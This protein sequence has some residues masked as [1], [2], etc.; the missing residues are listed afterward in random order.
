MTDAKQWARETVKG[1]W[2]SPLTP[3]LE[4]GSID[5]EGI[6]RNVDFLI[7]A[8][9]DGIGFGFS[10]PWVMSIK[11]R[12]EAIETFVGAARGRVHAYVHITD[13]S[14]VETIEFGR[15]AARLGADAV[16]AWT[17]FEWAKSQ[18]MIADFYQH[19]C[20][21]IPLP[22]FAYNTPHSGR[23]MTGQ[24]LD[25]IAD[26]P[27]LCA[28]KNAVNSLGASSALKRIA[29]D[30]LIVADPLEHNYP[31]AITELDQQVLLGTTSVYLMQS[32][33]WRP[34]EEYAA[35]FRRGDLDEGWRIY[36][37]LDPL[38]LF[39]QRMYDVLWDE[40]GAV[41]PIA[42]L[43]LWMDEI[44][45]RGGSLRPPFH[46][47]PEDEADAFIKELRCLPV[48][49]KLYPTTARNN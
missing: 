20:P 11:E 29:G 34:I 40:A 32:A 30:R 4:D 38:R 7:E 27:N 17:P 42:K 5:H 21:Q 37:S 28:L 22:V 23:L 49:D 47:V 16:M 26:I 25:R 48:M 45:M 14:T 8:G 33:A 6:G 35:A 1:L 13:H 15:H 3:F 39:W 18:S 12:H 19:I 31:L 41:H 2:A 43:K 9:A 10:E 36:H 46:P 24:T 44:G